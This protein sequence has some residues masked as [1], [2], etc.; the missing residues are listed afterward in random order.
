M[1]TLETH[2]MD[3]CNLNCKRCAHFSPLV[4]KD[5]PPINLNDII[6][7]L[8]R[9]NAIG[10]TPKV[11]KILGGEPL[12]HPNLEDFLEAFRG[13]LVG[14]DILI[15]TNGLLLPRMSKSFFNKCKKYNIRIVIT[16]YKVSRENKAIQEVVAQNPGIVKYDDYFCD[17]FW[18]IPLTIQGIPFNI[19]RNWQDC[20]INK[21]RCTTLRNHKLYPCC[22]PAYIKFLNSK[23]FNFEESKDGI[24]IYEIE[25]ERDIENRLYS[26]IDF[27]QY[28]NGKIFDE[29]PWEQWS[30]K[31]DG[32]WVST[33]R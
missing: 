29:H 30:E 33:S 20:R 5:T 22:F 18:E 31:N 4:P 9:L 1:Y 17:Y 27:C 12:L 32:G 28:C 2:I 10:C 16:P 24:N 23:G 13:V 11:F 25:N 8:I 26:P 14:V 15:W 19:E 6:N 21:G 7:D 3:Q